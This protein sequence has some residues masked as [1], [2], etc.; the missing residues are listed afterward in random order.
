MRRLRAILWRVEL[1]VIGALVAAG[2]VAAVS[3]LFG[4]V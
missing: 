4:L 3:G 2:T 1:V